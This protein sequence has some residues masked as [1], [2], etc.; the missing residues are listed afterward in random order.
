M[1]WE[2]NHTR[3]VWFRGQSTTGEAETEKLGLVV[4]AGFIKDQKFKHI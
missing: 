3:D 1:G 4:E 2:V